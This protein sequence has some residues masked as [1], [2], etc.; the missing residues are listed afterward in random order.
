MAAVFDFLF[1]GTAVLPPSEHV[2]G[3]SIDRTRT[4]TEFN[5]DEGVVIEIYYPFIIPLF[6]GVG[7]PSPSERMRLSRVFA[8]FYVERTIPTG[9]QVVRIRVMDKY[10]RIFDSTP[11]VHGRLNLP[12]YDGDA[13]FTRYDGLVPNKNWF[14]LDPPPLIDN[15][16]NMAITV[17]FNEGGVINFTGAGVRLVG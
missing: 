12:E 4:R 9:V 2:P 16:I 17:S 8:T 5:G 14:E 13:S 15:S 1:P 11:V 3:L 10:N 6:F 7:P